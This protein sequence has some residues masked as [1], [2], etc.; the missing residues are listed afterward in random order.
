VTALAHKQTRWDPIFILVAL[1]LLVSG[2]F[3]YSKLSTR[4]QGL[5]VKG[6]L[7]QTEVVKTPQDMARGLSGRD[8]LEPNS[9]MVFS[10]NESA[11]RC[12]WMKDMKFAIDMVWLDNSHKVTAI[13]RNVQPDTYP[14]NF[15]HTGKS[16][17]EFSAGTA[18]GLPL[19]V[20]DTV[21]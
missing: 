19:Y 10:Y 20:G 3:A 17:V 5:F 12:F 21:R 2:F 11:E 8:S 6:Q 13:E 1:L 14:N 16:V 4:G 15:C 9:A 18:D 7:F